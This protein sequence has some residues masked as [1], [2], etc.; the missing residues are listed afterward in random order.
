MSSEVPPLLLGVSA[1][2]LGDAVRYDAGHAR[3][4]FLTDELGRY[5]AWERVCPEVGVGMSIPRP[6]IRIMRGDDGERLVA[7]ST[8]DDWTERMLAWSEAEVE[9]LRG[10]ALDGFV[11]K[12]GSPSCGLERLKVY[13]ESGLGGRDGVGFFTRVLRARWPELPVEEEGR[14]NDPHLRE[15]FVQRVFARGRW[16]RF[17][18]AGPTRQGLI[19]FHTAHKFLLLAHDERIYRE[20]GPLVSSF[21]RQPDPEIIARYGIGFQLALSRPATRARHVNVMQHLLGFVKDRM[22]A[23][24]KARVLESIEDYRRGVVPLVVPTTLLAH[25]VH[26]HDAFYAQSQLYLAPCPKDLGLRNAV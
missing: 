8:G 1:C 24:Q 18:Q 21:G 2:L 23:A 25:L 10:L 20:L 7:P 19:E 4:R 13:G 15:T 12:R 5:T 14:L 6:A 11:V 16:R 22:D 3:D 17:L 26:A 9:R